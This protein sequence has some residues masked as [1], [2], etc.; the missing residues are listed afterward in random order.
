MT[1]SQSVPLGELND[2]TSL[3][4]YC[5]HD[6]NEVTRIIM[7]TIHDLGYRNIS[8][9]L[10]QESGLHYEAPVVSRFRK[11]VLNGDWD[12]AEE[13]ILQRGQ[14]ESRAIGLELQPNTDRDCLLFL[15]RR[16]EYLELLEAGH[17]QKALKLLRTKLATLPYDSNKIG[18][19]EAKRRREEIHQ[20]TN[21]LVVNSPAE[22]HEGILLWDG[23]KGKSRSLLLDAL[24]EFISADVLVPK[25]RL[26]SLLDQARQFQDQNFKQASS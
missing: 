9:L 7:Q 5:G 10:E 8:K 24:L 21:L 16:Q 6:R 12:C 11:A 19:E 4:D 3:L 1:A 17:V 23:A 14:E 20:L 2:E 18:L 25:F 15:I 13:L 26:A 22:L